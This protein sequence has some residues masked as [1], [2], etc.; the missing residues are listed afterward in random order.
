MST[1]VIPNEPINRDI[2]I[3]ERITA[4]DS[5]A[6]VEM[7]DRH[8]T[9]LFSVI[10]R[11]M[12]D[13]AKAEQVLQAL[14]VELWK[15]EDPYDHRLGNPTA[16]LCRRARNL[17]VDRLG[18]EHPPKQPLNSAIE[19]IHELFA[20]DFTEN[21]DHRTYLSGQQEEILISLTSLSAEQKSLIEFAYFRGFTIAHLASHYTVSPSVIRARIR[22][23]VSILRQKLR[24]QI[25]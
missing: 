8:A 1:A 11:T 19:S 24:H 25:A 20:A 18:A 2:A 22:T 13:K 7:Y 16:W 14:F 9:M 3:I 23:T 4:N 15:N 12:N 21:P 6:L 5:T 10:M 17:A